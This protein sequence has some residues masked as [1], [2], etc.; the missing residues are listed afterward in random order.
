MLAS[1]NIPPTVIFGGG[2]SQEIANHVSRLQARQEVSRPASPLE[3]Q[4]EGQAARQAL[5]AGLGR[6]ID[7]E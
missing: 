2:A 6:A 7:A 1:F 3:G 5:P 4:G